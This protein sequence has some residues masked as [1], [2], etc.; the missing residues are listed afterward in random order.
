MLPAS[1]LVRCETAK[2]ENRVFRIS[3]NYVILNSFAMTDF[4]SILGGKYAVFF[5]RTR[6]VLN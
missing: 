6:S 5:V 3:L 4:H 2:I 1:R